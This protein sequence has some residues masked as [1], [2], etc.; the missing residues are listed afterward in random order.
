MYTSRLELLGALVREIFFFSG[1]QQ[2]QNIITG[3]SA[4]NK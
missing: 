2:L 4:E 3:Q 1:Q